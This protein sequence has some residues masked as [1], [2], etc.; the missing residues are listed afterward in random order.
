MARQLDLEAEGLLEG[1]SGDEREGRAALLRELLDSGVEI[2][3]LREAVAEGRLPLIP[4]ERELAGDE[5][6]SP[7]EVAEIAGVERELLER[8]W[9]ALG[10]VVGDPGE[11]VL[12]GGDLE[13]AKRVRAFLDAGLDPERLLE[14]ARVMAMAMSQVAAANRQ[15]VGEL[16]GPETDGPVGNELEEARLLEG[17]ATALVPLVGP[18]LEHVYRLQ[19]REQLRHAAVEGSGLTDE[20]GEMGERMA[21]A[22]ADLVGFTRL[23]EQLPPEEFGGISSRFGELATEVAKGGVRLVKLI[24]DAA[25]LSSADPAALA[26]ATLD[27]ID[28]VEQEGE[29]LPA[30]HAGISLG[31]V[32]P[33]GGDFY[34]RTV[35]LASRAT[36]VARPGSLLVSPEVH[37]RLD[38][39]F[40]FSDA[41]T[42]RLKGIG[43]VRLFRCRRLDEPRKGEG[44]E[45]RD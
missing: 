6:Y 5:R 21:I 16:L 15:M 34:G 26:E 39:E 30:I 19:L 36:D 23:G 27:L 29:E 22:F 37:D 3:E 41:G 44:T 10:M 2:D 18:A 8:Q 32:V 31:P 38:G 40:S 33:H 1:V 11:P 43:R 4:V 35:N 13:A 25:M 24:G 20:D 42:K 17:I 14:T 28:L 7:N 12:T 9:Q 45:E